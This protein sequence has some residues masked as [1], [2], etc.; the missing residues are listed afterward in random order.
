M[1]I[2]SGRN[3]LAAAGGGDR[4]LSDSSFPFHSNCAG[5]NSHVIC[6]FSPRTYTVL[7]TLQYREQG[8]RRVAGSLAVRRL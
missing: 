5:R 7:T 1:V 4:T 3:G 6:P 2:R 8:L